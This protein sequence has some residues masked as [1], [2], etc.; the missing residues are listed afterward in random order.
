MLRSLREVVLCRIPI[1]LCFLSSVSI[2]QGS[3]PAR[4]N[5]TAGHGESTKNTEFMEL[6]GFGQGLR[7][8]NDDDAVNMTPE[9]FDIVRPASSESAPQFGEFLGRRAV[10]LTSGLLQVKGT[11]FRDGTLDLD[12]AGKLGGLFVGIAFRI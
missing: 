3:N 7:Q 11:R 12:V 5:L 2:A 1:C 9:S 10:Y 4:A 8:L 6:R